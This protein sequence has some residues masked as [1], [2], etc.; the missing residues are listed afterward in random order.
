MPGPPVHR[1]LRHP[2]QRR[3]ARS[4]VAAVTRGQNPRLRRLFNHMFEYHRMPSE[5]H[6]QRLA[7]KDVVSGGSVPIGELHILDH[8]LARQYV[9]S[10]SHFL[11]S[12]E[13]SRP[14]PRLLDWA[15]VRSR[16]FPHSNAKR[17]S[18]RNRSTHSRRRRPTADPSPIRLM[19]T[20]LHHPKRLQPSPAVTSIRHGQPINLFDVPPTAH[21]NPMSD[22]PHALSE[23][24]WVGLT[25]PAACTPSGG[26][27]DEHPQAHGWGRI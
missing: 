13:A 2:R 6:V 4:F 19:P 7:S 14:E 10:V 11:H 8:R 27:D 18:L 9:R 20:T 1:A 3:R 21:R 12:Q 24:A 15:A 26:C 23:V 22:T 16:A 25:A 5:G 17:S